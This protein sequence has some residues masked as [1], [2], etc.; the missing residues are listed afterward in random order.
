MAIVVPEMAI[1]VPKMAIVV[2]E[3]AIVV[4]EMANAKLKTL[5]SAPEDTMN[6]QPLLRPWPVSTSSSVKVDF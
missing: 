6:Y 4:P 5:A 1:V 3:M 2:P